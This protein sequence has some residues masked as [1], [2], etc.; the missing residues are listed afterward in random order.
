MLVD[1]TLVHLAVR[2]WGNRERRKLQKTTAR[3][4]FGGGH[5]QR[6][7]ELYSHGSSSAAVSMYNC[8]RP[9]GSGCRFVYLGYPD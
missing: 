6:L 7:T 8:V 4:S 9:H 1:G 3:C 5:G 2:A